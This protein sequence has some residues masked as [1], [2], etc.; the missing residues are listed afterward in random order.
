MKI[1]VLGA[2]LSGLA[3]TWFLLQRTHQVTV[4][5]SLGIG[6]GASGVSAGLLH[7][8]AGAHGKL[9]WQGWE[10]WH[11]TCRL[12]KVAEEALGESIADHNGLLRPIVS[13]GQREDFWKTTQTYSDVQW[14]TKDEC[15]AMAPCILP[16]EALWI[17][18]AITVDTPR[19]MQ[20]LWLACERLGAVFNQ[21]KVS[22][23]QDLGEYDRIVVAMGAACKTLPELA[24]LPINPVKG[25][26]IELEWPSHLR[27]SAFPINSQ[28]YVIFNAH[29]NSCLVGATYERTY[30]SEAADPQTALA[31]LLPKIA[32][33]I[34]ELSNARLISCRAGIRASTPNHQPIVRQWDA[35]SWII[36]GMGSK[37]LLY[38]AKSAEELANLIK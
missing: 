8:Y 31:L 30:P 4:L 27:K 15:A 20:G 3:A 34:P 24:Q 36:T 2:G 17:P 11:A 23:L 25:Q 6:G 13:A 12:L 22:S 37:G 32:A 9:N 35:R 16:S 33:S 26:V 28:A 38:H 19:Y 5:D 10:G 29:L 7:P 18:S 14:K 21:Q 1:V